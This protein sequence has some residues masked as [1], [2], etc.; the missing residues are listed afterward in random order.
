MGSEMCIRDGRKADS[1]FGYTFDDI[2]VTGY[3]PHPTI[4]AQVSV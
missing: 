4:K 2:S 3:D 1:I